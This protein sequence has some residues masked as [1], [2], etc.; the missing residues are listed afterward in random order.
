MSNRDCHKLYGIY[1]TMMMKLRAQYGE[2]IHFHIVIKD[3]VRHAV[4]FER[5]SELDG[6]GFGYSLS[7]DR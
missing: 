4:S 6:K 7:R 2:K 1:G 3:I 5:P